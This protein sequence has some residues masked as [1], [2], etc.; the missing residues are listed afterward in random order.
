VSA[1]RE[2][3]VEQAAVE[4]AATTMTSRS[5]TFP[6]RA[7]FLLVAVALVLLNRRIAPS[8]AYDRLNIIPL[9]AV[10]YICYCLITLEKVFPNSRFVQRR[11][12]TGPKPFGSFL[13]SPW[14][15][16]LL[17]IPLLLLAAEFGLRC[18][19][20]HRALLY[21]RQGNLL[22]TPVPNQEY[23][24]KISLTR[25]T[26]NDLG[27]RG[28]PVDLSN[29][30]QI[31]LALGDS[32]T[33]GYGLDDDHTYVALLQ[34]TLDEKFPGSYTVLNGGVDGYPVSFEHEKFLYLWNR[35]V[36]PSVVVVG[37]SFNEGGLGNLLNGGDKIKDLFAARVRMKNQVRSI[38]LYN[39]VIENWARHNYDRMKKYMVPGT[40]F[41]NMP[42]GDVDALYARELADFVSDM[43]AR[44]VKLVFMLFCGY[45]SRT[46][47]YDDN[48]PF[49]KR[50]AE[51]AEKNGIPLLHSK[52]ALL[53]GVDRNT[54][55]SPLFQDQSHMKPAG[56]LKVA[57]MVAGFLPT[58]EKQEQ[59]TTSGR[60]M[61][62]E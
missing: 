59:A 31:V 22:F 12:S 6:W 37:Y 45:N 40:N 28:G 29:G 5:R 52:D 30:R 46:G 13:V 16:S 49:Q 41:K 20:C 14:F 11:T 25:S 36:H 7:V 39:F 32:I 55:V 21:E 33:Y 3:Y 2:L 35:G 18:M 43:R 50:F 4:P 9:L 58:L 56:N 51:F 19:H 27:L 34:K 44:N 23:N 17:L 57:Q 10:L 26:I 60:L 54:D 47:T 48:G 8:I 42:E 24:E 62:Q 1:N 38:A 15:G 61:P 53:Q